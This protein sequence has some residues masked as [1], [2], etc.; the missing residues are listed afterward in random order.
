MSLEGVKQ[1]EKVKFTS[2]TFSGDREYFVDKVT[3]SKRAV[4]D[5]RRMADGSITT[6]KRFQYL[7]GVIEAQDV[8][9]DVG[10]SYDFREL[11]LAIENEDNTVNFFPDASQSESYQV[12]ALNFDD[13]LWYE[14]EYDSRVDGDQIRFITASSLTDSQLNWY[15]KI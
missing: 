12:R 6:R 4:G 9:L 8:E 15:R 10:S 14:T 5:V 1:I 11:Q 13:M 3:L 7:V 2:N